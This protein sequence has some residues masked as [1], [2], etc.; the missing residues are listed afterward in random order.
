MLLL[1]DG[2]DWK[3]KVP[4]PYHPQPMRQ[5]H[6]QVVRAV[7]QTTSGMWGLPLQVPGTVKYTFDVAAIQRRHLR[8]YRRG[9]PT[10]VFPR[11]VP[12]RQHLCRE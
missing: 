5:L 12:C 2:I 4:Q 8:Y 3:V 1:G 7:A 10:G 6:F 9:G 11:D